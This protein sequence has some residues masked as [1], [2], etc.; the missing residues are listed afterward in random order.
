MT[1]LKV[2][3]VALI[4]VA[5][6]ALGGYIYPHHVTPTAGGVT[7]Y[8][9]VDTTALK[10]GGSSGS[11]VGPIITGTCALILPGTNTATASTSIS[12]D[13]AVT[14]VVSGDTVFASFA[15][16]SAITNTAALGWSVAGASAS[17]TSGFITLRIN[18][19]TG[20][21]NVPSPVGSTTQYIVLH[22]VTSVPGL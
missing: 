4:A 1:S 19:N 6:I 9:E 7:N 13:C 3:W 11:R 10:V 17:S 12:M 16:S 22:P 5:I 20:A 21:N 8:D 2:L 15:T 14:G 18:N